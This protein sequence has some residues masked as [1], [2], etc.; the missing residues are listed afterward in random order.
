[1][2][3][4]L[5]EIATQCKDRGIRIIID[6][7]SQAFQ[8]GIDRTTLE[9]MRKWNRGRALIWNTYQ[10][11]LKTTPSLVT[12]H[13]AEAE[14]DGFILGLKIV[15]GAYILSDKRSLIHDTKEDTDNTYNSIAQGALRQEIGAFGSS[16]PFPSVDLL[17]ASHNRESLLNAYDL[18][19]QRLA[20]NLPT[21]PVTY[22]QLHGMS[23]DVSFSLLQE[24]GENGGPP[25]VYKCSTW[26]SMGECLGYLVRRAV[27]NRDAV[28]RTKDEFWALR[29]E[30]G[31]RARSV[32]YL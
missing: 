12:K 9:L 10:A 8:H 25:A 13:L 28:L 1:M 14:K 5:D 7:E 19:R 2:L 22:A 15:R 6:A 16:R 11:Y 20:A 31:R 27:E 3:A 21:V 24:K 17:L 4:A 26:G 18:H 23:D 32:F 29:R 30:V